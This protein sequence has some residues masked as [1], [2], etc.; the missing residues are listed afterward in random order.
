MFRR[1]DTPDGFQGK[2]VK[3]TFRVRV[4][5]FWLIGGEVPG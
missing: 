2:F 4:L 1:Y 3:A 5:D